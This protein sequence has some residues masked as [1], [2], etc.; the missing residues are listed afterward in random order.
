MWKKFKEKITSGSFFLRQRK[1]QTFYPPDEN[2]ESLF[3]LMSLHIEA[4]FTLQ[5]HK[6]LITLGSEKILLANI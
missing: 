6:V 5:L 1:C 4:E 2:L 3:A